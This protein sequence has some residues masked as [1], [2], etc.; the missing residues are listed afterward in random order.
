MTIKKQ[1]RQSIS[2][3]AS[4]HLTAVALFIL[5]ILVIWGTLYQ[6]DNGIYAAQERFFRAWFV[7]IAGYIPFPAVKTVIGILTLN[8]I[9]AALR[10]RPFTIRT[11]GIFIL[12]IGVIILVGGSMLTSYYVEESAITLGRF[13][14]TDATYDFTRW[15]LTTNIN[16]SRHG[17]PFSKT[18]QQEIRHLRTG[19]WI[20]LK[21]TSISLKIGKIF[22]NCKAKISD[23]DKKSITGLLPLK[24]DQEGGRNFPG[25]ALSVYPKGHEQ[26]ETPSEMFIYSGAPYTIPVISENDTALILLQPHSIKL[27]MQIELTEF[28]VTWHPGTQKEKSFQTRLRLFGKNVDREVVIEMNRPFRYKSFTFY[29]MGY[30]GHDGNYT[31]TLAI[32]KNPFR[33]LP[34]ISSLIIVGGLLFHFLVKMVYEISAVKGRRRNA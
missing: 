32:V 3:L 14:R 23:Q 27:P 29:Q 24:P 1:F 31:S 2:F 34:Y 20:D 28:N 11:A 25:V 4:L 15:E 21:P 30:S 6:V 33:Y 9:T 18:L 5:L 7:L 13:Q 22:E 8:L 10:K 26:P 17:A 19:Q 16:G 12:H